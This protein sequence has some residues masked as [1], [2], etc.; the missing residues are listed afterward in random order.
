[1]KGVV[2]SSADQ[3][4]TVLLQLFNRSLVVVVDDSL[5]VAA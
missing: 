4:V 3:R 5:V 1:M 2:L